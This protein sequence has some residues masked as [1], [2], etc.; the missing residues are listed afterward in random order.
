MDILVYGKL[1]GKHNQHLEA[2]LHKLQEANL[3]LNEENVNSQNR[4]LNFWGHSS[5]LKE[6]M[7]APRKPK[8][9]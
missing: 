1:V 5:T 3:T 7:L 6:C 2:A 9:F 8:P 4:Q